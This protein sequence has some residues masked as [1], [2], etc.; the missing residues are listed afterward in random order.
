MPTDAQN[1]KAVVERFY[2]AIGAWDE[3]TLRAVLHEDA[4]LHQ[5]P[6]LPYGGLAPWILPAGCGQSSVRQH[7]PS[8]PARFQRLQGSHA[9][10]IRAAM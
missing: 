4:E 8:M 9:H 6:T 7:G 5:P 2:G 10:S 1:A 3:E